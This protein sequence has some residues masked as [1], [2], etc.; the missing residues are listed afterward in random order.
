MKSLRLVSWLVMALMIS[1]FYLYPAHAVFAQT[2]RP[3]NSPQ[4]MKPVSINKANVEELQVVRGIGPALAERIIE[5]REANGG[6]K[7]L[8]QLKEVRGIGDAK[9]E[10]LKDQ[11]A[12]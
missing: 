8:E 4:D 3:A 6:F 12:L 5:Y 11:I 10:K 2:P 7:S 9:F 1:S